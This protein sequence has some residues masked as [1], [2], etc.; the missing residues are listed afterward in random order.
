MNLF[1]SPKSVSPLELKSVADRKLKVTQTQLARKL[2]NTKRRRVSS[3]IGGLN[4]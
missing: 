4:I 1:S 3:D 2:F